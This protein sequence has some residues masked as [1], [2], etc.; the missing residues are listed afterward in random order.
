MGL[1]AALL[2]QE[3]YEWKRGTWPTVGERSQQKHIENEEHIVPG[4]QNA[5]V[6]RMGQNPLQCF[7]TPPESIRVV[8]LSID[9]HTKLGCIVNTVFRTPF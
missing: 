4:H 1:A 6:A 8:S 9:I 7:P 5:S 2:R 3:S